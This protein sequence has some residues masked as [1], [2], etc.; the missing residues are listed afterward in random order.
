M[1]LIRACLCA[2]LKARRDRRNGSSK[3]IVVVG[4]GGRRDSRVGWRVCLRRRGLK[5]GW[6][7][8]S[9]SSPLK[10][11]QRHFFPGEVQDATSGLCFDVQEKPFV[12]DIERLVRG[13]D[14][15]REG[16]LEAKSGNG[17]LLLPVVAFQKESAHSWL[18]VY[19][20]F[21]TAVLSLADHI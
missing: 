6:E 11:G 21:K 13:L 10:L 19:I 20:H 4:R 18:G 16:Q 17:A 2:L 1:E 5:E 12:C 7:R 14:A 3:C 15:G 8:W 9:L